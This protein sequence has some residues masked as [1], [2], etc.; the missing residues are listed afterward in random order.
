[1]A[2]IYYL[3]TKGRSAMILAR[4]M[5]LANLRWWNEQTPLLLRETI[6]E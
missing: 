3:V 4:L 6:L 1:M 5:A 2:V